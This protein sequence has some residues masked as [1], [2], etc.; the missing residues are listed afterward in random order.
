MVNDI[1]VLTQ[2]LKCRVGALSTTYWEKSFEY[3]GGK[4]VLIKRILL[5]IHTYYMSLF[6]APTSVTEKVE[7]I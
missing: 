3:K 1:E 5:S 7:K 6:L 4:E 2:V